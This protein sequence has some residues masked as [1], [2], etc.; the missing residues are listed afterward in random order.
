[1]GM[2]L[3]VPLNTRDTVLWETLATLGHIAD[4]DDGLLLLVNARSHQTCFL[5][6]HAG[7]DR[8]KRGLLWR[9][10]SGTAI[11]VLS[12]NGLATVSLLRQHFMQSYAVNRS[13]AHGC[14]A[15]KREFWGKSHVVG[16]AVLP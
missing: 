13:L 2:P 11:D 4:G 15:V 10:E 6:R 16:E 9:V 5:A 8:T 12:R 7:A 1:M 3:A 14:I